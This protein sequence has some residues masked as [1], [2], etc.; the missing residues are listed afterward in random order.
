LGVITIEK[1]NIMKDNYSKNKGIHCELF[2][3]FDSEGKIQCKKMTNAK[4]VGKSLF[5]SQ[6]QDY[7]V[8][9]IDDLVN[10]YSFKYSFNIPIDLFATINN[11]K[12]RK[13]NTKIIYNGFVNNKQFTQECYTFLS[14]YNKIFIRAKFNKLWI[15]QSSNIMWI[16]NLLVALLAIL[17]TLCKY[18][19]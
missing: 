13:L 16:I 12:E 4:I 5:I 15:Q 19:K 11:K 9:S 8:L 3:I 7:F 14:H 18:C 1:E 17:A 6:V 10:E 2:T